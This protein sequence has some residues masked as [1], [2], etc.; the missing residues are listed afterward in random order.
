ME[1]VVIWK[2]MHPLPSVAT[3]QGGTSYVTD[4]KNK[5]EKNNNKDNPK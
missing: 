2:E 4:D 5:S 3:K 1:S